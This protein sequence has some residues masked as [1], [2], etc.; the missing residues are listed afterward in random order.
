MLIIEAAA[1]GSVRF[2][3]ENCF[4]RRLA[5][6][7]IQAVAGNRVD[8][9]VVDIDASGGGGRAQRLGI[10]ALS[11]NGCPCHRKS[12]ADGTAYLLGA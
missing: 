12:V 7:D 1:R 11:S 9:E 5:N 3:F 6:P 4:A 8:L 2:E 10:Y